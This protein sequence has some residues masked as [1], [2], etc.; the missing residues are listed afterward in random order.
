MIRLNHYP[1]QSLDFFKKI[2]MTRGAAD[3]K[4]SE[5]IRDMNYFNKYNYH[6]IN[7]ETLKNII[8]NHKNNY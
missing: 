7:D 3:C 8:L 1:I 4:N 5:N 2:K 6:D